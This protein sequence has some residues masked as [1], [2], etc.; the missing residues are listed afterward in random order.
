MNFTTKK[1]QCGYRAKDSEFLC[2]KCYRVLE[3]VSPLDRNENLFE[4]FE[5]GDDDFDTLSYLDQI[6]EDD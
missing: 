4:P 1:C 5:Q 3:I 2:P 6:L